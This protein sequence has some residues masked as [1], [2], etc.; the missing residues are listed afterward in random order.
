MPLPSPKF[1]TSVAGVADLLLHINRVNSQP[2]PTL[3]AG[4]S[5]T[6]TS[7]T[8]A[9]GT[10]TELPT[11]NFVVTI[12]DEIIFVTSRTAD[13]CTIGTRGFEGTTATTHGSGVPVNAFITALAHNQLASEINSVETQL[14][15]NMENV[16]TTAGA[17]DGQIPIFVATM[18]KFVPGDPIVSGPDAP[19]SPPSRPPVQ[20]GAFDGTNVQRVACDTSGRIDVIASNL[21]L[22]VD[23]SV[24][25]SSR[26][27]N[28]LTTTLTDGSSDLLFTS[29]DVS[30]P[31][32]ILDASSNRAKITADGGLLTAITDAAFLATTWNNTTPNNTA[33]DI[34]TAGYS[35][36]LVT[37]K[38][39]G[40]LTGG[41][42]ILFAGVDASGNT[43][44]LNGIPIINLGSPINFLTFAGLS[45][46]A[47]IFA[48]PGFT[49][50]RITSGG[51]SITGG[52]LLITA[53][54]TS[55][56]APSAYQQVV[57][58]ASGG[59]V[60]SNQ[61]TA[62]SLANGW[63]VKVTDGTN[64]LGTG[65]NPVRIDPTGTTTQPISASSLP[66]PT[67]AAQ[68]TGGN[69]ALLGGT[70]SGGKVSVSVSGTLTANQG[71]AAALAS[72]WPVKITD[73][74]NV[75]GTGTNPVRTDPTGTT[76]QPVSASSLPLPTNAAQETGGNLAT[77]AGT[78]SGGKV[79]VNISSGISN[80]L[81]VTITAL[82]TDGSAAP[83]SALAVAGVDGNGN[84]QTLKVDTDGS[85]NID[86]IKY[87]GVVVQAA[88]AVSTDG[89]GTNEVVR[90]IPRKFTTILSTNGSLLAS[91]NYYYPGETP[92][93]P[94]T[95]NWF[96]SNKTGAN[97]AE[98]T[99]FVTTV[100]GNQ[101]VAIE[102]ADD[103]NDLTVGSGTCA[104]SATFSS[105]GQSIQAG[106]VSTAI[107]AINKRFWR[108]RFNNGAA[109]PGVFKFSCTELQGYP[110]PF[111]QSTGGV[112]F[113]TASNVA[114]TTG[115]SSAVGM[116]IENYVDTSG[117]VRQS[118]KLVGT[119]VMS[120]SAAAGASMDILRTPGV[121][122]SAAANQGTNTVWTPATG[123]KFRLMRY[124]IQAESDISETTGGNV[125]LVLMDGTPGAG[126]GL[127]LGIMH[128]PFVPSTAGT[129][130][131]PIWT[132]DWIDLGNGPLSGLANNPL[133]LGINGPLAS[134]TQNAGFTQTSG[135]WEAFQF[136]FKTRGSKG[137]TA[138]LRSISV[139]TP[140]ST[141]SAVLAIG[142]P[143][144]GDIIVVFAA[145]KSGTATLTISDTA[146]NVW[147]SGTAQQ[148]ATDTMT[149][150]GF[151]ATA[152]AAAADSITVASSATAQ[153]KIIVL[154]YSG[155]TVNDT[156][157]GTT[158]NSAA[159]APGNATAASV[160]D[161]TISAASNG[162]NA[163]A[164]AA[165]GAYQLQRTSS[166]A[167]STLSV[168][169]S[170]NQAPAG[171][172][173]AFM[174][175]TAG[176]EE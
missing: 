170:L 140:A 17:A 1:P 123:K 48:V 92:T 82:G 80:P 86:V 147:T 13:V 100:S 27:S 171:L 163:N 43:F 18:N 114:T 154:T 135:Q 53:V 5:P 99:I 78:V 59:F 158:G 65:T 45:T 55:S 15:P 125:P 127:G 74:T 44:G 175:T 29:P 101:T 138:F 166:D 117:N 83:S 67:N 115:I 109:T 7:F 128:N 64:I 174:I 84:L 38:P 173:G 172:A 51:S 126:Q 26:E 90:N 118:L 145:Q 34:P 63:P 161:V 33:F 107:F 152:I 42:S 16:A 89:T 35:H 113:G 40:V 21:P 139:F 60:T 104:Q 50:L 3:A 133:V 19:G 119:A 93:T 77:L 149:L 160:S 54:A 116:N 162:G 167:N 164:I 87:G 130:L 169:D 41:G 97:F 131:G 91:T 120:A 62:G 85:T 25:I 88:Q 24:I 108:L 39:S 58:L 46:I 96:D 14:G 47:L 103:I 69:L 79:N 23:G 32:G 52:S 165:A 57:A 156:S 94:T 155:L 122:R 102:Q 121:F 141:N 159:P 153:M 146:G 8:V 134:T 56:I 148:N 71:S 81:P 124:I 73:G 110:L 136:L 49:K 157:S 105:L 11:D 20:I 70:V 66:L 75:L 28:P 132:T 151:F 68:E 176:T 95:A 144:P 6:D 106:I 72:G 31:V 30:L 143:I 111:Q 4:I 112:Q 137:P 9:T 10:G 37:F 142:T 98:A 61:G 76:T 129:T 150:R 168:E 12:D 36:V 22:A 2:L